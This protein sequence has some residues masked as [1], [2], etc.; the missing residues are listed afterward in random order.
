MIPE[1]HCIIIA[2]WW[3]FLKL[4]YRISFWL[5]IRKYGITEYEEDEGS[6]CGQ[7]NEGVFW[8]CS[9]GIPHEGPNGLCRDYS[10]LLDYSYNSMS[11]LAEKLGYRFEWED[12][13]CNY[14]GDKFGL[15]CVCFETR[16]C[17]IDIEVY[18]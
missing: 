17:N 10:L 16:S 15:G 6:M 13:W 4:H 12:E 7:C 14:A 5:F 2:L 9:D 11:W 1:S 3:R 18:E 8:A